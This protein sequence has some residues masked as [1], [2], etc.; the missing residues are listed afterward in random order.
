[1]SA[2]PAPDILPV[3]NACQQQTGLTFLHSKRKMA[4]D[5]LFKDFLVAFRSWL[6]KEYEMKGMSCLEFCLKSEWYWYGR[7]IGSV[8]SV[9]SS[10]MPSRPSREPPNN[11]IGH[12]HFLLWYASHYSK[13]WMAGPYLFFYLLTG[14]LFSLALEC[15]EWRESN[16]WPMLGQVWKAVQSKHAISTSRNVLRGRPDVACWFYAWFCAVCFRR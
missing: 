14:W 9:T 11:R 12:L 6:Q 1:M 3:W 7:H 13:K 16:Q 10:I 5:E 8:S 15:T 2:V 4:G